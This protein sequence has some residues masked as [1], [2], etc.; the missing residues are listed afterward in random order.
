MWYLYFHGISLFHMSLW[1]YH[2]Y[3]HLVKNVLYN[4]FFL[5]ENLVLNLSL[6]LGPHVWFQRS[7]AVS[8][9][10]QKDTSPWCEVLSPRKPINH[11]YWHSVLSVTQSTSESGE[12]RSGMEEA[13]PQCGPEKLALCEVVGPS[14]DLVLKSCSH[15]CSKVI[16]AEPWNKLSKIFILFEILVTYVFT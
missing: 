4:H 15:G 10:V 1:W 12:H 8:T 3:F 11:T 2:K 9:L 14:F 13:S 5:T 7:G 16:Y 6:T